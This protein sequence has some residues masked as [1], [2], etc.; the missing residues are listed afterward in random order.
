M[1]RDKFGTVAALQYANRPKLDFAT[2]V[3]EFDTSFQLVDGQERSQ[4]W[5]SSDLV[6]I[7]RDLVRVA[8]GWLD[9]TAA[10]A[11]WH[12][13]VAVG[14]TPRQANI[15]P[16]PGYID[17]LAQYIVGHFSY[18]LPYDALLHGTVNRPVSSKVIRTVADLLRFSEN[19]VPH[20]I[21]P[22]DKD[23]FIVTGTQMCPLNASLETN[24]HHAPPDEAHNHD[25]THASTPIDVNL[26]AEHGISLPK[27]LTIY[28]L[29]MTM[30]LQV[31]PLGAFLLTYAAL[32][33]GAIAIS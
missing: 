27:R 21:L 26:R 3:R 15:A 13:I 5:I 24:G 12:L 22:R 33:D 4:T 25:D 31:P 29:G 8:L 32:R 17:S 2:I 20:D 7:D 23:R 1:T 10:D 19:T 14:H 18:L 9:P 11:P 16:V 28:T 30:A 6:I